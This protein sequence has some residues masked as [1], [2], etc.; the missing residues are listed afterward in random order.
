MRGLLRQCG[1]KIENNAKMTTII[2]KFFKKSDS[3][4]KIENKKQIH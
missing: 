3:H 2:Y 1:T 4:C